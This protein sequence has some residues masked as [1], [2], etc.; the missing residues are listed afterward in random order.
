MGR[1]AFVWDPEYDR[2]GKPPALSALR[3][4]P[5]LPAREGVEI[6]VAAR[7]ARPA[8]RSRSSGQPEAFGW[9]DSGKYLTVVFEWYP[10]TL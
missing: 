2:E 3:R 10:T 5:S 8:A 9:T 4:P 7:I 1:A 6:A